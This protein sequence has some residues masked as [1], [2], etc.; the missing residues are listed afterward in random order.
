M[1]KNR[2]ARLMWPGFFIRLDFV[3]P[4][5]SIPLTPTLPKRRTAP[6]GGEGGREQIFVVL[7]ICVR[8]GISGRCTSTIHLG[9]FPLPLG[10][11]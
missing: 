11:G 4:F 6:N 9:Q 8:L 5:R 2:K 7:K 10:E 3:L 1:G